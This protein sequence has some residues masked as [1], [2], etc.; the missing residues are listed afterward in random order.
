MT[1]VEMTPRPSASQTRRLARMLRGEPEPDPEVDSPSP[2]RSN[3]SPRRLP[4]RTT[5]R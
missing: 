5:P 2:S 3:R 4:S 1:D